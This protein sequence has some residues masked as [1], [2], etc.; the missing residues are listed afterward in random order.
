MNKFDPNQNII[1]GLEVTELLQEEAFDVILMNVQMPEMHGLEATKA[2]RALPGP[3]P[4]IVRSNSQCHE[5]GQRR[6]FSGKDE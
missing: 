2:I 1:N 6:M 3:Q 4:V 5:R